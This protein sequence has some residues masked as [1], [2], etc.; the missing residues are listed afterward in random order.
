MDGIKRITEFYEEKLAKFGDDPRSVGWRDTA[1]QWTRFKALS[2]VVAPQEMMGKR[3]LD[4]GCG[5]GHYLEFLKDREWNG[6]YTGWDLTAPMIEKCREKFSGTTDASFENINVLEQSGN[7]EFDFVFGSGLFSVPIDNDAIYFD[8][9]RRMFD[10]C[11]TAAAF[12]FVSTY[13]DF[14][15]DYLRYSDPCAM[16]DFCKRELSRFVTL[17]H[18]YIRFEFT[19]YVYKH[20]I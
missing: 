1:T 6:S 3:I 4:V 17:R 14:K 10:L 15:E 12:N 18:D 2:E 20:D 11:R 9:M 13:V 16:F 5:L 7:K 8:V 19:V